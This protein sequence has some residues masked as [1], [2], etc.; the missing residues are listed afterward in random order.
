[1]KRHLRGVGLHL[2]S[3]SP[4]PTKTA[5]TYEHRSERSEQLDTGPVRERSLIQIAPRGRRAFLAA[6][7]APEPQPC[8]RRALHTLWRLSGSPM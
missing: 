2:D 7:R 4:D 1:V 6:S 5:V 3:V 8:A